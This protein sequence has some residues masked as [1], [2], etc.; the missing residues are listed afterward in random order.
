[1]T[2]EQD[3]LAKEALI[4]TLER[5][6]EGSVI[7][8]DEHGNPIGIEEHT[9]KEEA[10]TFGAVF[11]VVGSVFFFMPLGMMLMFLEDAYLSE[12][13][14]IV[15][16]FGIFLLVGGALM[17]GGL[18]TLFSGITGKGLTHVVTLEELAE[19]KEREDAREPPAF[20]Y[21]SREDL[22]GQIHQA[23]TA[24]S[25]PS[26]APTEEEHQPEGGFWGDINDQE[27]HP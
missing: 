8:F 23:K 9:T 2:E 10:L 26:T 24:E 18:R 7:K 20:S 11:T 15:P 1:M 12:M 14:C 3:S 16:F 22:L 6:H 25:A 5:E 4:A 13:F 19:R 21:A 27:E 17:A